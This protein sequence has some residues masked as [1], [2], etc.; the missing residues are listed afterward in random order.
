[1]PSVAFLLKIRSLSNI[2]VAGWLMSDADNLF[3]QA[4]ANLI[5][6]YRGVERRTLDL[7][8]LS[9]MPFLIF[10]WAFLRFISFFWLAFSSSFLPIWSFSFETFFPA[11]IGNI[12]RFS[13]LTSTMSGYG[14]G[15]VK[16]RPQHSYS[17]ARCW[18]FSQTCNLQRGLTVCERK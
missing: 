5:A 11:I 9:V 10:L 16:R 1:V 18:S 6:L 3:I 14:Y 17:F 15:E 12:D 13:S 8:F 4:T 7:P 2:D